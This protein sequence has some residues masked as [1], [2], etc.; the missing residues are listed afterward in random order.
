VDVDELMVVEDYLYVFYFVLN[1]MVWF[2]LG[3]DA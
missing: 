3:V 2:V 1:V